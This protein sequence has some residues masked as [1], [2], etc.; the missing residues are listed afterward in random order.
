MITPLLTGCLLLA[1]CVAMHGNEIRAEKVPTVLLNLLNVDDPVQYFGNH[2][3]N[4][5]DGMVR[6]VVTVDE[7]FPGE[8]IISQYEL[9]EYKIRGDL[10]SAYISI[11]N[12]RKL[13]KESSVVFIR[14]PAAFHAM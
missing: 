2:G 9:S 14:L 4:L 5:K 12:L 13:C 1:C 3:I 8:I 6:V 7:S 10:V 11:D